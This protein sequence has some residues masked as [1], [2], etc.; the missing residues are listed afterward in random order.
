MT[1]EAFL[2]LPI[3]QDIDDKIA[4]AGKALAA[5]G[6]VTHRPWEAEAGNIARPCRA[7]FEAFMATGLPGSLGRR[8]RHGPGPALCP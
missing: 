2:N 6:A 7:N 1:L 5:V 4:S 8:R 3:D